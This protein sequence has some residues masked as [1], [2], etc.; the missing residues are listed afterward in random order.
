MQEFEQQRVNNLAETT[1]IDLRNS[2]SELRSA[3]ITPEK[4]Y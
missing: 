4:T 3:N 1:T 2:I